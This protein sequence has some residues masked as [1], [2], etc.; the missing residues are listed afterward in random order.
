MKFFAPVRASRLASGAG[1]TLRIAQA[2]PILHPGEVA[3]ADGEEER[4]SSTGQD[5]QY[6]ILYS[7]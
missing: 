5:G 1:R 6:G 4:R 2:L 7:R 3:K